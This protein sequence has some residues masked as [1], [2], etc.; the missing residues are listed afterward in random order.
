MSRPHL[1]ETQEVRAWRD[2]TLYRL[3][4]RASRAETTTTLRS[5]HE[6]GWTD[7]TLLD[8]NLLAN[9]DTGGTTISAL[10]VRAG[11]TRQAASQHVAG[12]E[13]RG[14][15]QRTSSAIDARAWLVIQTEKGRR[16]L[17][18]ALDVVDELERSYEVALGPSVMRSLRKNLAV[19]L[20]H[21]DQRGELG[22]DL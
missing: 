14:F 19:F 4:L 8:T 21:V 11:F 10:A 17:S 13:R 7:V 16:L 12:L 22:P 5:L 1:D 20:D 9:L 6:K 3:L 15:V 18:D 2:A